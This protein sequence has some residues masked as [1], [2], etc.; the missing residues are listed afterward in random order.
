MWSV[1][2]AAW[3]TRDEADRFLAAV[4]AKGY[5]ARIDGEAAPFR[6]RF[7]RYATRD[8]A[9]AA[10]AEYRQKERADAFLVQVPR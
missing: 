4:R 9:S 8:A 10:M 5:D 3:P 2:I 6:V 1:Q 7:G